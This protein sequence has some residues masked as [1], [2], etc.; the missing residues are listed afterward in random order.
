LVLS[1]WK[2]LFDRKGRAVYVKAD[3]MGMMHDLGY[4]K[5]SCRENFFIKHRKAGMPF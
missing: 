3:S 4:P 1:N 5:F 2:Y